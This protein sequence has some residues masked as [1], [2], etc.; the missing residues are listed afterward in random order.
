MLLPLRTFVIASRA[1]TDVKVLRPG[2]TA[3]IGRF[4]AEAWHRRGV[5][6]VQV[7]RFKGDDEG[8]I[9]VCLNSMHPEG[10][11]RASWK[12]REEVEGA[13]AGDDIVLESW[14]AIRVAPGPPHPTKHVA[15]HLPA[16]ERM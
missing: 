11:V 10:P 12:E 6:V 9:V 7:F 14:T 16:L 3:W 8:A 1:D 4:S 2:S 5:L 13:S 15:V